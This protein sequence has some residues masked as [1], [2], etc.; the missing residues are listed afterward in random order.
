MTK[1][2]KRTSNELDEEGTTGHPP[3][4]LDLR[5]NSWS[6]SLSLRSLS[7][8]KSLLPSLTYADD[9]SPPPPLLQP[10]IITSCCEDYM[11][12]HD[13]AASTE[14]I[15]PL[16]ILPAVNDF[17][18]ITIMVTTTTMHSPEN[19]VAITTVIPLSS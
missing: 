7:S 9:P 14:G 8:R 19:V 3:P 15:I 5:Q 11:S 4:A 6:Q 2:E 16:I 18:T 13:P 10:T 17:I 1:K 12:S